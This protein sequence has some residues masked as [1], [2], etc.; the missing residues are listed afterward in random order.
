MDCFVWG[1]T[2]SSWLIVQQFSNCGHEHTLDFGGNIG[3]GRPRFITALLVSNGSPDVPRRVISITRHRD[4][5]IGPL[6]FGGE[7]IFHKRFARQMEKSRPA[8]P[9]ATHLDL[10]LVATTPE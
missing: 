2:E 8:Q 7:L 5:Q 1:R 3:G 4:K 9:Q 10:G 6:G